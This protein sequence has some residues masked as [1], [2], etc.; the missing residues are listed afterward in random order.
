MPQQS[1]PVEVKA[2]FPEK[3]QVLFRPMRYKIFYGGRG[4]G[5]SWSIARALVMIGSKKPLRVLCCREQQNSMA[6]SVHKLLSDQ[7]GELGLEGFYDIQ[8][9]R[10]I[11]PNGTSFNFEGI[12]NNAKKIRSYEGIDVCWIEE[13]DNISYDSM[14]VL[15]PTIRKEQ[16]EIWI[17]FN[18]QL[19]TDYIYKNFVLDPQPDSFVVNVNYKD[20][21]WFPSTLEREKE[22]LKRRDF[23]AYLNVWEGQCRQILAGAV[24][25]EELREVRLSKRITKVPYT[26]GVPV[27]TFWDLGWADATSIWFRQRVGF[28]W[29]YIDYYSNQQKATD[30]Y[31]TLLQERRYVYGT[32]WLPHDAVAKEKGSGMSVLDRIKRVYPNTRIV[33]RLSVEDGIDA[34]RTIL[35]LCWFDE[36]RCDAGIEC[37]SAYRYEIIDQVHGNLSRKPVHDWSSHGA[38][39]F[40]YSAVAVNQPTSESKGKMLERLARGL[41][42]GGK[43]A[44]GL[45]EDFTGMGSQKLHTPGASMNWM[46]K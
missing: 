6:E 25:A 14:L 19:K 38:D 16:S 18:P 45:D 7:I 10:I 42:L 31:M 13:G 35:P 2:D 1:P 46:N 9:D 37:L 32:H 44:D 23:D 43:S 4:S 40:R 20:N 28:E 12:K 17:S 22:E 3:M 36:K 41:G 15:T 11:A 24:Y 34:G 33:K 30:H 29:H 27:D 39:G 26:P 8:R 21:P 5:K